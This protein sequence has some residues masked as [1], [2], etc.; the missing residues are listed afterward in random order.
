MLDS[1]GASLDV[2]DFYTGLCPILL[3]FKHLENQ[4]LAMHMYFYFLQQNA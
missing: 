1:I 3:A 4:V 2:S